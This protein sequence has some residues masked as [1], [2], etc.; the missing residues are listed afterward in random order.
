[1]YDALCWFTTPGRSSC[2]ISPIY[3]SRCSAVL[4]LCSTLRILHVLQNKHSKV[5]KFVYIYII[6]LIHLK[7]RLLKAHVLD[8]HSMLCDSSHPQTKV[9]VSWDMYASRPNGMEQ[10]TLITNHHPY[11]TYTFPWRSS[12]TPEDTNHQPSWRP[13]GPGGRRK[14]SW[15]WLKQPA[16]HKQKGGA[17]LF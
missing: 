14:A 15:S 5:R 16:L 1:M 4:F 8:I 12:R 10:T 11:H 2:I 3:Y 6:I 13:S 17:P 9:L 7:K